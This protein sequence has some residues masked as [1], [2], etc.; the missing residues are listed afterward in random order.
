MDISEGLKPLAVL[1]VLM[2]LAAVFVFGRRVKSA[3]LRIPLRGMSI[4]GAVL[5]SLLLA[6]FMLGQYACTARIPVSYSPDGKY[7]A[8]LTWGLQGALGWD[9]AHIGVRQRWSPYARTVYDGPGT[10]NIPGGRVTD[11]QVRWLDNKHLLVRYLDHGS[12]YE[13]TCTTHVFDVDVIC[14]RLPPAPAH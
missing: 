10:S 1:I 12:G 7:A 2:G 5:T 8:I 9:M 6:L 13:Q 4:I 14:Q 3:W 11:P